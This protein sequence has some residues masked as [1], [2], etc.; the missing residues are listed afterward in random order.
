LP[1]KG[2]ACPAPRT[3]LLPISNGFAPI[4]SLYRAP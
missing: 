3:S 2:S 4:W 1:L